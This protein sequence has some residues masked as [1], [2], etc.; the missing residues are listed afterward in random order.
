MHTGHVA[1]TKQLTKNQNTLDKAVE[2]KDVFDKLND[3]FREVHHII[4]HCEPICN[5]ELEFV[6]TLIQRY[7]EEYRTNFPGKAIPK[8]HFLEAHC[9]PWMRRY[10]FG[11]GLHGEQG[12][13]LIHSTMS[14]LQRIGKHIRNDR[15]RLETVMTTQLLMI[16]P[17]LK[18]CQPETK[19]TKNEVIRH[20]KVFLILFTIYDFRYVIS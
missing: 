9:V 3:S 13:E 15:K 19:K 16:S 14:R 20:G 4:S 8:Q 5:D 18:A 11:L 17:D 1:K 6:D 10:G 12:G 2:T 7:M